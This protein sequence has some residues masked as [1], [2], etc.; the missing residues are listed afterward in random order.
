MTPTD[1]R[2]GFEKAT[3][4]GEAGSRPPAPS[5]RHRCQCCHRYTR[6]TEYAQYRACD[7]CMMN[8]LV[9]VPA[10]PK[11]RRCHC[12]RFL[13]AMAKYQQLCDRCFRHLAES[14]SVVD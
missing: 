10:P 3:K 4:A 14:F 13:P 1:T 2:K 5:S 8:W 12:G 7:G 11:P 9:P 6:A